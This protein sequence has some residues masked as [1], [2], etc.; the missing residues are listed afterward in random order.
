MR[1]IAQRDRPFER[2]I[3]RG[4]ISML[5]EEYESFFKTYDRTP[6]LRIDTTRMDFVKNSD[7]LGRMYKMIE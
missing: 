5:V 7:D 4:Y 6:V 1:R 3:D 2:T